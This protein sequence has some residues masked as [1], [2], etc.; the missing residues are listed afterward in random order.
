M[1]FNP[2]ISVGTVISHA[3]VVDIFKCG[4]MGGMRRSYTTNTLV[5]ISDPS[6]GLYRDKWKDGKIHYTGMGKRGD[7]VLKGNQNYTLFHADTNGVEVHFFEA[8]YG[9]YEYR[10]VVELDGKPYQEQQPDEDGNMRKVWMF[11]LRAITPYEKVHLDLNI[12]DD[13]QKEVKKE[14]EYELNEEQKK[15]LELNPDAAK[16]GSIVEV[17]CLVNQVTK[18]YKIQVIKDEDKLMLPPIPEKCLGRSVGDEFDITGKTY[19]IKT[20]M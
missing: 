20:V 4:N 5:I 15:L 19:K 17:L 2:G 13:V 8:E 16:I 12:N 7:Q 18:K 1:S 9:R 6:K 10:G 14:P 11:P 3:D